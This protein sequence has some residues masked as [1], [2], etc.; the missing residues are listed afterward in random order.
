MFREVA[1]GAKTDRT[2]LSEAIAALGAGDVLMVTRLD[3]LAGSTGPIATIR[4]MIGSH[5][6]MIIRSQIARCSSTG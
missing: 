2:Q 6:T 4:G 3:R 1:G 5:R